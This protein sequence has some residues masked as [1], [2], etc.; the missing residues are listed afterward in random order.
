MKLM[1]QH[2]PQGDT[3]VKVRAGTEVDTFLSFLDPV[4]ID[5]KVGNHKMIA[6]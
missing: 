5:A 4:N 1:V 2:A 3:A 6:E